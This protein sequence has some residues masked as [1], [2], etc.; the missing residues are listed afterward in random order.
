MFG[1]AKNPSSGLRL[2]YGYR[3]RKM[4]PPVEWRYDTSTSR[5]LW[6]LAHGFVAGLGGALVWLVVLAVVVLVS[7]LPD[8]NPTA[9]LLV[10]LL[11]LVGGPASLLYL[12]PMLADPDQRPSVTSVV[13]EGQAPLP[14]TTR[15]VLAAALVGAFLL[16]LLAAVGVPV[17]VVYGLVVLA[18]FS[19]VVL[20]AF[21]T[22]GSISDDRLVC[23][24]SSVPVRQVTGV[25]TLR[26][27]S[28]VLCWVSYA[29]GTGLFSPRLLT[30]PVEDVD[31]VRR[32]LIAVEEPPRSATSLGRSVRLLLGVAGTLF[33]AVAVVAFRAVPDAYAGIYVGVVIGAIGL[34]LWVVAWRGV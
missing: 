29:R 5:T 28:V 6:L 23:N 20:N 4:T 15:S 10:G 13:G 9:L 30:V 25:R 31:D 32:G 33:V 12:W 21:T 2:Q 18:V 1:A 14:W 26:V 7:V 17:D 3:N 22:V 34:L 19:P 16:G 27:G 11:F 24:G 8:V